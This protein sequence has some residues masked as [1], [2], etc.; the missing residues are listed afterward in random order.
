MSKFFTFFPNVFDQCYQTNCQ[1]RHVQ[2]LPFQ[3]LF[4]STV[5]IYFQFRLLLSKII[6]YQRRAFNIGNFLP[7]PSGY[8]YLMQYK[9]TPIKSV[10]REILRSG[11]PRIS[12]R[13]TSIGRR[14][15]RTS[16]TVKSWRSFQIQQLRTSDSRSNSMP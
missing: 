6:K 7:V 5:I 15:C 2:R 14:R 9:Q 8:T 13:F 10:S 1:P 16:N 11:W 4:V 3:S 12:N